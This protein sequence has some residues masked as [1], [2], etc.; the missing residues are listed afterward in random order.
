MEKFDIEKK[1]CR[2]LLK[3]EIFKVGYALPSLV[4]DSNFGNVMGG[5]IVGMAI[6]ATAYLASLPPYFLMKIFKDS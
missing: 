3:L 5:S 4:Q 1:M 6:G 2:D